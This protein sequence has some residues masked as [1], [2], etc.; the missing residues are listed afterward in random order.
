MGGSQVQSHPWAT[1]KDP[2]SKQQIIKKPFVKIHT[3]VT[4][5]VNPNVNYRL[6]LLIF[7]QGAKECNSVV[8]CM[9]QIR[10]KRH[11]GLQGTFL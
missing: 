10:R 2:L 4:L 3:C 7:Y 11:E 5:K 6:L 1:W 8:E 9:L